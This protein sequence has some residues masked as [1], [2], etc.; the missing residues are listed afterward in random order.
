MIE[1][2]VGILILAA[3]LMISIVLQC[4]FRYSW[5]FYL[6]TRARP[7]PRLPILFEDIPHASSPCPICLE[8]P[9]EQP[10][11]THCNHRYC[12]KCIT[13]WAQT[14]F[15]PQCPLCNAF[16]RPRPPILGGVAS[17]AGGAA[18]TGGDIE[19]D[20]VSAI[21]TARSTGVGSRFN[22]L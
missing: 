9:M 6:R 20:A 8:E 13:E 22:N 19:N 12:K 15:N 2:Y 1:L 3:L 11:I 18:T 21:G 10:V 5:G 17:T 4:M 7:S 16:F 14:R